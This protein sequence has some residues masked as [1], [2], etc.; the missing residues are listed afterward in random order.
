MVEAPSKLSDQDEAG[1]PS[2]GAA[3]FIY[4]QWRQSVGIPGP[5]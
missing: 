1:V 2:F 5:I 4:G 3:T